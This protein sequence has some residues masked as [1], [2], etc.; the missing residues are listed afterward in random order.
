MIGKNKTIRPVINGILSSLMLLIL[1]FFILTISNSF[2]HAR[3]QFLELWYWIT[4]LVVGFGVQVGIYTY[5]KTSMREINRAAKA[6]VAAA[7]GVSTGAMIAC[8]LHHVTDVLPIVGLSAAALFLLK[9][10]LAFI[11]LGVFSTIVGIM[12]MLTIIQNHSLITPG[13]GLRRVFNYNMKTIRNLVVLISVF[14]VSLVFI[15]TAL[16]N[17]YALTENPAGATAYDSAQ[18]FSLLSKIN[19]ENRVSIEVKPIDFSFDS[20]VKFNVAIN[21]HWDSLDFDMTKISILED[22]K[23][24]K[25]LPLKWDGSPPGGHHRFGVLTF[26]KLKGNTS[27]IKLIIKDVYGIPERVFVWRLDGENDA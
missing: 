5:I 16:T 11:V 6:E 24:N 2:E 7:G 3:Q 4:I 14:V 20:E 9:Y 26:P 10:Q 15:K 17:D 13:K 18:H 19:D 23:G 22:D 12:M 25:Y 1:Y 21:T 27:Y 8:C